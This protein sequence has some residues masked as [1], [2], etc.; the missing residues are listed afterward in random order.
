[1]NRLI[2]ILLGIGLLILGSCREEFWPD[3]KDF[4]NMVVIDGLI[5]DKPGPYE[6]KLSL[7]TSVQYPKFNPLTNAV[8]EIFDSEGVSETL[9]EI[10]DGIYQTSPTGIQGKIG[11]SYRVV[12]NTPGGRTYESEFQE[13]KEPVGI[14]N[15]YA[16]VEVIQTEDDF[17]P[18]YGYQFYLDTEMA[19]SD[20]NYLTWR[21]YGDYKY[22]VDYLI[23]YIYDKR[24]LKIFPHPDSLY[25]CFGHEK[26]NDLITM[27]TEDLTEPKLNR[28]PLNFVNTETKKLSI[29][30]SL[31]VKQLSLTPEAYKFYS[32]LSDLNTQ[33]G[34]LYTQQPFQVRGNIINNKD[35]N[36]IILGYFLAA[37]ITEKRIFVDRPTGVK[38]RYGICVLSDRDYEAMAYLALSSPSS[39]PLYVTTDDDGRRALPEQGCIDC[40]RMGGVVTEPSFWED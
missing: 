4:E 15:I 20:T 7:S 25:T 21:I 29:R 2:N 35:P 24:Q 9:T 28:F 34:A 17:Y 8:V 27:R 12:I 3:L 26:I 22:R 19:N 37:G 13:I 5:T 31:L 36:E 32:D 23:R 40:R 33:E 6:V 30:Y 38:F 39:W 14:E 1:M 16:E 18:L 10:E 11:Q